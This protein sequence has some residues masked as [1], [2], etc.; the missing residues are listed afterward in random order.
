MEFYVI[1]FKELLIGIAVYLLMWGIF[2]L[3]IKNSVRNT[4]GKAATRKLNKEYKAMKWSQ[5]GGTMS[6]ILGILLFWIVF[7]RSAELSS[8]KSYVNYPWIVFT[9]F[10]FLITGIYWRLTGYIKAMSYLM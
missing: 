5:F 4:I 9:P 2:V 7:S 6:I 8:L 1:L 10:I 3:P